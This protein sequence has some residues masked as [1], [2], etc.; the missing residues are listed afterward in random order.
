[1]RLHHV[2][3]LGLCLVPLSGLSAQ[4]LLKNGDFEEF[5]EQGVPVGWSR[6]GGGVPES[7]LAPADEA[8]SGQRSLRL[9]DTGP[10][11]RDGRWSIGVQQDVPAKPGEQFIASV[12]VKPIARNHDQAVILQLTFLPMNASFP[13]FIAPKIDGQWH[14][15]RTFAE[16]PPGTEFVRLYI[17]TMH[18]WTSETLIDGA[19]LRKADPKEFGDMLPLA[20]WSTNGP[21]KVREVR[22]QWPVIADGKPTAAIVA[23]DEPGYRE[24]AQA[25]A[26]ALA[27]WCNPAPKVVLV[28]L[29]GP[30][31][32]G[33]KDHPLL[34]LAAQ[35][36]TIIAIG[37]LNTNPVAAHMRFNRRAFEDSL[38]PGPGEYAL[39]TIADPHLFPGDSCVIVVGSSDAAG[40]Q[41]GVQALTDRLSAQAAKDAANVS[42]PWTLVVSNA[43]PLTDAQR[44]ELLSRK[45]LG[46]FVEFNGFA[47]QYLRTG[48]EAYA[49]AAKRA[50]LACWR[51]YQEDPRRAVTWPEETASNQIG[52]LWAAIEASPIFTDE[53]RLTIARTLLVCLN[54]LPRHCSYWG[55]LAKNDTIIWNHTTFPLLGIYWLTRYFQHAYPDLDADRMAMMMAEVRGAFRGQ[56]K[57]WKP[58][59]DADSYLTIVPGHEIEY[60]LAE[61]D[62]TWFANGNVR[63]YADYLSTL[64]DPRGVLPGLGDSGYATSPGYELSGLPMAFWYYQD[65]R[66]LW[67]LNRISQGGKWSNP[68]CRTVEPQPWQDWAGVTVVPLHEEVYRYTLDKGYYDEGP[69]P[70]NVPVEQTFDKI[71]FRESLEPDGQYLL[72]DGYSR[73]KHLHWD[74]NA[75]IKLHS[76]GE[77]WLIDGDYLVRNTTEHNMVSILRDGRCDQLPPACT[78]LLGRGLFDAAA[79]TQTALIDY[80]GTDWRRSIFWDRG[81][82]FV[83]IDEVEAKQAGDYTM[84]VVWKTL[85]D[86]TQEMLDGRIFKTSRWSGP[87]V[88]SFGLV[89]VANPAPEVGTAVRFAQ[90]ESQLDFPLELA[91]GK[92]VMTTWAYGLDTGTDS[93]W[94]QVDGGEKIAFHI[95]IGQFGPSSDAHTKDTPTPNITLAAGGRHRV[96]ISLRENPGVMLDRVTF[97]DLQGKLVAE[98]QAE[99]APQ[100]AP[101]EIDM[102]PSQQ[103]FVVGDGSA[104][105]KFVDRDSNVGLKI[106]K[107]WQRKSAHLEAGQS[108]AVSNLLYDDSSDAPATLDLRP[109]SPTAAIIVGPQGSQA[110]ARV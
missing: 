45:L 62:F 107:L 40:A 72:L 103:F 18:F 70:P 100:F 48:D 84:D 108:L 10:N 17:Y 92:Y 79:M 16:A 3:V 33:W 30:E 102:G 35:A 97:H 87:R 2:S 109:M 39:R 63:T 104:A 95:P 38:L 82:W 93:F 90:N 26:D 68:Y 98:V 94:V 11:E 65:P 51:R 58:Q 81:K 67:R 88:G 69:A 28:P 105:A 77:N 1:M 19:S 56:L 61:N 20:A 27:R 83:V 86:G 21:E 76:R 101:G 60:T 8:H 14:Q 57:C 110:L 6:Y 75:I 41:A 54:S 4:E 32:R 24:A 7:V 25:L 31:L 49:E 53:D 73:G 42:L 23:P 66:F 36:P 34:D 59:C 9:L 99:S 50:L 47:E 96:T 44:E 43:K 89:P 22:R 80:N 74:G 46:E 71:A 37:N 52:S 5:S 64:S 78:A 13:T 55:S 106:R 12:W 15:V 29:P 91:A 85:R